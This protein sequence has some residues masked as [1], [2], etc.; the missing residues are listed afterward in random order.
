MRFVF[1]SLLLSTLPLLGA[2]SDDA[3][4]GAPFSEGGGEECAPGTAACANSLI[5]LCLPDGTWGSPEACHNPDHTCISIE[6]GAGCAE[7]AGTGKETGDESGDE[8]GLETGEGTGTATS[9]ETGEETGDET[10]EETGETPECVTA[11]DCDDGDACTADLCEPT[12]CTHSFNNAPCDDKD[13]CTS[14]DACVEGNCQGIALD[15][16]D[17]IVCTNDYCFQG[18]CSN[19][20]KEQTECE[21][22]IVVTT[23][24][25][26]A[27]VVGS[28]AITIIGTVQSPVGGPVNLTL[29]GETV[30]I[31]FE[32]GDFEVDWTAKGGLNV[33][34]FEASN[35]HGQTRDHVQSFLWGDA[36]T[37]PG[38]PTNVSFIDTMG[39]VWLRDDIYDDDNTNTLDDLAS[40]VHVLLE[41][42]D[43]VEL[44]P[45]PLLP[46]GEGPSS[47]GCDWE[48]DLPN[49]EPLNDP[50]HYAV[51]SVDVTPQAGGIALSV[52]LSSLQFHVTAIDDD[53][54]IDYCPN[55]IG[56]VYADYTYLDAD[57]GLGVSA[58]GAPQLTLNA[59]E[60]EIEGI[61]VALTG[62][63]GSYF[64]WLIN[65]LDGTLSNSIEES[66]ETS[67]PA[68]L[69]PL[70]DGVLTEF[71]SFG[72]DFPVP[73]VLGNTPITLTFE[74]RLSEVNVNS[75]GSIMMLDAGFAA[76]K[77]VTHDSPG[78]IS[79][80]N[81]CSAEEIEVFTPGTTRTIAGSP[82]PLKEFP[83]EIWLQSTLL[84][85]G[86]F[87][88]WWSGFLNLTLDQ[89]VLGPFV[90]PLGISNVVM[91]A[92]P[93]L[94]PVI[95]ACS[96]DGLTEIQV[97]DVRLNG[98]FDFNG[99]PSSLD[100]YATIRATLLLQIIP[101]PNGKGQLSFQMGEILAIQS[102]V[103]SISSDLGDIGAS[104]I[105]TLISD[106]MVQF[107]TSDL[108]TQLAAAI[109]LPVVD[110][111]AYVPGIPLGTELSF[112]P[113]I[114]GIEGDHLYLGG[115]VYQP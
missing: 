101:G 73:S 104:L 15:C 10:G 106:V 74:T 8:T 102:H 41:D 50:P 14:S 21:L 4:T 90:S 114:L 25:R 67:V 109:P 78:T 92:D 115:D 54:T 51:E 72:F 43:L 89:S 5:V 65:W 29:N 17:G 82:L 19:S 59:I 81:D 70:L 85:Q 38:T 93:S 20:V 53:N 28:P 2:C 113:E 76:P 6:S 34:D 47:F 13:S 55:A 83:I 88:A 36:V 62:G 32:G 69:L 27:T 61:E 33:L 11:A 100:I 45:H 9:E 108:L 3:S 24:A 56:P 58:Q 66:L 35:A 99:I 46:A 37:P 52:V 39:G 40:L 79:W 91:T 49:G 22:T 98:T 97:G 23:P 7:S 112:D 42:L 57:I 95:R 68:I 12:G 18:S 87:A 30:P 71:T 1:I 105:E 75:Q 110:I 31:G 44:M 63:T 96:S 77:G 103:N 48:I 107:L 26:A 64:N 80:A 84:N 16:D 60:V 111:G 94:P 86:A